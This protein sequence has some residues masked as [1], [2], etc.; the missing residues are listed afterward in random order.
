VDF[1]R[2]RIRER[3]EHLQNRLPYM[4]KALGEDLGISIPQLDVV[5]G[6]G[7]RFEPDGVADY[8]RDGFR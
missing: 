8:E 6:R 3:G 5:A 4:A 2:S 1:Y 7:T